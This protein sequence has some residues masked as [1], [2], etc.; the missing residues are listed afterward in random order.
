MANKGS[1]RDPLRPFLR[2]AGGK[3][4][5]LPTL[6]SLVPEDHSP[7]ARVYEPFLGGGA[8]SIAMASQGIP[9]RSLY[10]NDS[11]PDLVLAYQAIRDEPRK[12]MTRLDKISQHLNQD[13]YLAVR[14]A[15]PKD[16]IERA[17]RFIYLN[18]TCFNGLWRVN[19]SGEFNVPFGK[20]D[21][22][23]IYDADNF[24][25]LHQVLQKAT[26]T[27]VGF[28]N[29]VESAR[30]GDLVYLDPPYL[31]LTTTASFSAYAR[32]GFGL[33]D[34]YALAGVI[35]GLSDRGVKVI[36]SNSD[37]PATRKIFGEVLD[38]HT[39]SVARSISAKAS[40]RGNVGEL[41]GVNYAI[42]VASALRES[43]IA[44]T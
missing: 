5:L 9:G 12:L 24:L 41:I 32:D 26:V 17:A 22:P 4:K 19:S 28:A 3:R 7:K 30:P 18:R 23:L 16:S 20:L 39:I 31:P 36:L 40:S 15:R 25:A 33:L 6:L 44:S 42:P 27:S 35:A 34:H 8:F 11:N 1:E 29:A 13:E 43:R 10:L 2:W 14:A 37:T 38:L 21:N